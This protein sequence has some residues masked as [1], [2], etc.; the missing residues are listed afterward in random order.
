M[1]QLTG[2]DAV[3][4]LA[5]IQSNEDWALRRV[6]AVLFHKSLYMFLLMRKHSHTV[7]CELS[8]EQVIDKAS[9]IVTSTECTDEVLEILRLGGTWMD[10]EVSHWAEVAVMHMVGLDDEQRNAL[11][12]NVMAHVT[13]VSTAI[14]SHMR[15]TSANML[16]STWM[17]AAML[18]TNPAKAKEY[19]AT[20]QDYM[21]RRPPASR[22]LFERELADDDNLMN[23]LGLFADATPP[24]RLWQGRG[25]YRDLYI[26]LAVRFLSAPDHVLDA[27]S[28]HALWKWIE[29]FKRNVSFRLLNAVLRMHR[30][31][32]PY[33]CI[34]ERF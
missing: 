7:S 23:Q 32:A 17:A 12:P 8:F 26:F 25:R 13:E 1:R 11:I 27:E 33:I 22:T 16:R 30:P 24:Q 3:Q 19:A 31:P 15:L 18:S 5:T 21:I 34:F 20:F 28:T 4:A 2:A 29:T 9:D 14:S 10:L 6:G